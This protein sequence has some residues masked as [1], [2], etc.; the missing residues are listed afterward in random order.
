MISPFDTWDQAHVDVD[1]VRIITVL[2]A[3]VY[4][5]VA[6]SAL[7]LRALEDGQVGGGR[8]SIHHRLRRSFGRV[9]IPNHLERDELPAL[10]TP[11]VELALQSL[12]VGEAVLPTP[13]HAKELHSVLPLLLHV[14]PPS[15]ICGRA[16]ALSASVRVLGLP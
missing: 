3:A 1:V 12:G 2:A 9:L 11:L 14:S 6:S 8:R 4:A 16:F 10:R 7:R 5:P 13:F 15:G